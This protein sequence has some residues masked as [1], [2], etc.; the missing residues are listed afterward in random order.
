MPLHDIQILR[1]DLR[2]PQLLSTPQDLKKGQNCVVHSSR[3]QWQCIA[4]HEVSMKALAND[5]WKWWQFL[6][7]CFA[8]FFGCCITSVS[9]APRWYWTPFCTRLA[10]GL[11]WFI[12]IK[13]CSLHDKMVCCIFLVCAGSSF[14]TTRTDDSHP[15]IFSEF[16]CSGS[17]LSLNECRRGSGTSV[18]S[19]GVNI[20]GVQCLGIATH[21]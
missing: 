9:C 13:H 18:I 7:L 8:W 15:I 17:E 5:S 20:V 14:Y 19:C 21:T 10:T 4:K 1:N 6:F 2:H 3:K 16:H 11:R 12:I